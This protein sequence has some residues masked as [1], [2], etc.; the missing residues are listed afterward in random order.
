MAWDS[1]LTQQGQV[2]STHLWGSV[3]RLA[4]QRHLWRDILLFLFVLQGGRY[5][6][7]RSQSKGQ[8]K[9]GERKHL[10]E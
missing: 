7:A 9:I 6:G 2:P 5:R 8:L 4:S 10:R 3:S 1:H